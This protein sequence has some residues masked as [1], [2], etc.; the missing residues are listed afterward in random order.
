M[1]CSSA[2]YE[3]GTRCNTLTNGI[4][5]RV[6]NHLRSLLHCYPQEPLPGRGRVAR[7]GSAADKTCARGAQ[8]AATGQLW[9]AMHRAAAAAAAAAA[10]TQYGKAA[11]SL[12]TG[13]R[14]C[15]R[16]VDSIQTWQ[17]AP[18]AWL[19]G[20]WQRARGGEGTA[21]SEDEAVDA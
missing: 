19:G 5:E 4:G 9:W 1:P 18:I 15:S 8:S 21:C 20:D 10:A 13:R 3:H 14:A 6:A 2:Q 17:P 7:T 12:L 16:M 11:S